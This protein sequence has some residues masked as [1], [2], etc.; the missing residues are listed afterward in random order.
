VKRRLLLVSTAALFGVTAVLVLLGQAGSRSRVVFEGRADETVVLGPTEVLEPAP[1]DVQPSM[2]ADQAYTVA[3]NSGPTEFKDATILFGLFTDT[4]YAT[5]SDE[6]DPGKPVLEQRPAWVVRLSGTCLIPAL[7]PPGTD[8]GP[9]E[10]PPC[11]DDT[12]NVVID[13]ASGVF[14]EAFNTAGVA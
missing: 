11:E 5:S 9:G 14:V 2:T 6:E 4:A 1:A 10:T 3:L 7:G 12:V 8:D 13:D